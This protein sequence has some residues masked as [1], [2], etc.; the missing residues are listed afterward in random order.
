[1][2]RGYWIMFI[3]I[4]LIVGVVIGGGIASKASRLPELQEKVDRLTQEN[5]DLRAR[6]SSTPAPP[7]SGVVPAAA[8]AKK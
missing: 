3:A 4:A 2:G 6:L 5:A 7:A 8:P 1:M